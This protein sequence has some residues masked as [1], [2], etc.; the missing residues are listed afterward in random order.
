VCLSDC[1]KAYLWNRWTDLHELF[2]ARSPVGVAR[3]SS[4]GVAI[5]GQSLMSMNALFSLFSTFTESVVAHLWYIPFYCKYV[6]I[7][8]YPIKYF[9]SDKIII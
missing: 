9:I 5:P 3:S 2:P 8:N 6:G 1:P 4:G 7:T